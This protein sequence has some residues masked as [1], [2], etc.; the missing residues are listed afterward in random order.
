MKELTK[1]VEQLEY[2]FTEKQVSPW[3]RLRLIS[4]LFT[5]NPKNAI[6]N[7]YFLQLINA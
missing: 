4:V 6:E 7:S 3:E 1:K 2:E 5:L